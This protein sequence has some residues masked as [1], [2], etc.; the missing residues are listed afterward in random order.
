MVLFMFASSYR[1]RWPPWELRTAF[2]IGSTDPGETESSSTPILIKV[3]V[4]EQ[5]AAS[6]PQIPAHIPA[7][8]A[9]STVIFIIFRTAGCL[10]S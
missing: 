4:R 7:S 3:S 10:G 6:S 9:A 8:C 1:T 5:S 2:L